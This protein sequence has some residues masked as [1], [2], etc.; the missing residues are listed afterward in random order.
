ME[1]AKSIREDFLMQNAFDPDDTYSSMQKQYKL[2]KTVL[3][4]LL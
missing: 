1:T 4:L 3:D 2:L